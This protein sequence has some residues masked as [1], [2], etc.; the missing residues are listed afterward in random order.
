VVSNTTNNISTIP[1]SG[2][3][4]GYKVDVECHLSKAPYEIQLQIFGYIVKDLG[5]VTAEEKTPEWRERPRSQGYILPRLCRALK[6]AADDAL[7]AH[8]RFKINAANNI[9]KPFLDAHPKF[10]ENVRSF[11]YVL[12]GLTKEKENFK[13]ID[14]FAKCA[15]L[16]IS[17]CP[18]T[19]PEPEKV[20]HANHNKLFQTS[21]QFAAVGYKLDLEVFNSIKLFAGRDPWDFLCSLRGYTVLSIEICNARHETHGR[22]TSQWDNAMRSAVPE[23][24]KFLNTLN[25][26]SVPEEEVC[27]SES[28]GFQCRN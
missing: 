8:G 22:G 24:K 14:L 11:E 5:T 6:N 20:K 1:Q 18:S 15:E 19:F 4:Y 10:V 21:T 7:Y 13:Q 3:R 9:L 28:F 16:H 17:V 25:T 2:P 27:Q 23:I 26:V 12:E